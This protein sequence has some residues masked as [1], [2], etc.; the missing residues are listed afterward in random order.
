MKK[1]DEIWHI[2]DRSRY[3]AVDKFLKI[4]ASLECSRHD[5]EGIL[6]NSVSQSSKFIFGNVFDFSNQVTL[7]K[8]E[9]MVPNSGIIE[10]TDQYLDVQSWFYEKHKKNLYSFLSVNERKGITYAVYTNSTFNEMIQ[11]KRPQKENV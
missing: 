3:G 8:K 7:I 6:I 11:K 10:E 2:K 1:I 5:E 9:I 4:Q